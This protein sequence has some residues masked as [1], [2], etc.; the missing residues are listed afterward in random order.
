MQINRLRGPVGQGLDNDPTDVMT[1]KHLLENTGHLDQPDEG[2][3]PF[4]DKPTEDG[5]FNIQDENGLKHDGVLF[6]DGPT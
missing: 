4:F 5:V 3:S 2:F 6:A 1:V